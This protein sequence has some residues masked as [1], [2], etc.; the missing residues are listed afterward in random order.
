MFNIGNT[1]NINIVNRC[2]TCRDNGVIEAEDDLI[3]CPSCSQAV[4]YFDAQ[5]DICTKLVLADELHR[6]EW[7]DAANALRFAAQ[8][9]RE[10]VGT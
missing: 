7:T 5:A 6:R 2:P 3:D 1:V 4:T 9:C 10:R 8:L